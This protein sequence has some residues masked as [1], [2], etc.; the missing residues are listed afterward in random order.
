MLSLWEKHSLTSV[1]YVTVFEVHTDQ[2]SQSHTSTN[3]KK[4]NQLASFLFVSQ[5]SHDYYHLTITTITPQHIKRIKTRPPQPPAHGINIFFSL[6]CSF[7]ILFHSFT[8]VYIHHEQ[9]HKRPKRWF[10]VIWVISLSLEP[11]PTA[12][13]PITTSPHLCNV[14]H[15]HNIQH[16]HSM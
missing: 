5:G 8:N 7:F 1:I 10:T 15:H 12:P 11:P 13:Q 9:A 3:L 16:H 4:K 6:V 2:F 14:Q